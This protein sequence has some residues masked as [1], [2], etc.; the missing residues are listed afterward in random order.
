MWKNRPIKIDFAESF[1]SS[2]K[3]VKMFMLG[4]IQLRLKEFR[5]QNPIPR[6][7]CRCM[8]ELEAQSMYN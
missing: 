4:F 7:Y 1:F 8:H 6:P 3:V 2:L 5:F